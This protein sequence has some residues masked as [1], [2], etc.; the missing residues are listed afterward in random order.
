MEVNIYHT[1][2]KDIS[3]LVMENNKLSV[4][5][6][7]KYGGKIQSIYDKE[8]NKELLYQAAS[9]SY[10]KSEYGESFANGEFSGFDEMF[11]SIN[12]CF[13]HLCPWRGTTIPDHGEVWSIPWE[14]TI[15]QNSIKMSTYGVRFPYK[16]DKKVEFSG[17]N[18]I[19]LTYKVTNLA[20]HDFEFIWAAHPLFNCD[21]NT[22]IVLPESVD[23]IINAFG[24]S[25]RLGDY[26]AYHS[27]P[28]TH[29]VSGDAYNMSNIC[30]ETSKACEKYYVHGKIKEGWCAIYNTNTGSY[31][32]LTFP[33]EQVP[34]LGIWL[35]EGGYLE[36][37]N[38][39]LEPCTGSFDAVDIAS[40]RGQVGLI[41]AKSAC[42]WFL[43]IK[44][45]N[46]NSKTAIRES[47]KL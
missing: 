25:E 22:V 33:V 18:K 6:L 23:K 2:Y 20:N 46:S 17:E 45:G 34:Y 40:L 38:I 32:S 29:T 7:P 43:N 9:K 12:S 16:L 19:K 21:E 41:K 31:V 15:E 27:W 8:L 11:P 39:A 10:I 1:E 30:P 4:K 44:V 3:C 5:L 26:G 47:T 35:N 42:E 13:Y 37:Y 24:G 28:V 14:Y 36:Q